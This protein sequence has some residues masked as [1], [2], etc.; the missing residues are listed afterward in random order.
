MAQDTRLENAT[1]TLLAEAD[2]P[3]HLLSVANDSKNQDGNSEEVSELLYYTRKKTAWS[4]IYCVIS[5]LIF[6]RCNH[7]FCAQTLM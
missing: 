5:T 2:L 7:H 3:V 6:V 1:Q 4:Q